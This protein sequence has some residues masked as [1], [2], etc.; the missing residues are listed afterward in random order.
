MPE[1]DGFQLTEKIRSQTDYNNLPIV[2]C[3]VKS[4]DEDRLHG[5]RLGAQAYLVKREFNQSEFCDV[6][7]RLVP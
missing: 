6:V 5:M 4:S 1:M 7:E 3:S 2:I